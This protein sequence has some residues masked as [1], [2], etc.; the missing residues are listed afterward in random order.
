[1]LKTS[2]V[3]LLVA[4]SPVLGQQGGMAE[5]DANKDNKVDVAE[6]KAY[7]LGKGVE[8]DRFDELMKELDTDGDGTINATEFE[9]RMAGIQAVM[10]R[11]KPKP[12]AKPDGP[13]EFTERY[14]QR[15]AKQKPLV[16]D[17]ISADLSAFDGQGK[18]LQ[19]G[20]TRGK[21][22]VIVFGCLT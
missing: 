16:G 18:E 2:L 1:M 13:L 10:Q 4:A 22:T 12:A 15:F 17:T 5:A 6:L 11:P 3:I 20:A 8:F 9:G 19:L 21:Y 7:V 14:E